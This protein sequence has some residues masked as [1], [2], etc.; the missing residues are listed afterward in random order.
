MLELG[1]KVQKS[2][3]QYWERNNDAGFEQKANLK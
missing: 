3:N 1:R 2:G